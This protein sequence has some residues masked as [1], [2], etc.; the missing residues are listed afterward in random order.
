MPSSTHAAPDPEAQRPLAP[1]GR[2]CHP[3]PWALSAALLLLAAACAAC[4]VRAWAAPGAP[5][6]QVP[7][8][9][10]SPRLPEGLELMPDARTRL[11]DSPQGVFAQLVVADGVQLTE[12]PLHWCSERGMTGVTLAPGVS[13]DKHTH[14]VVVAQAGVYYVFLHLAL[15]R[16]MA[17]NGNSSGSVSVALNLRPLQAGAA[18][19]ALTLDLPPPSSGNSVAGFRSG[20]LHLDAGQRLSV[21]LHLAVREPR[22][23][24]LSADATVLGLFHVN[25]QVPTG[26]SLTQLT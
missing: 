26:L 17:S 4:L 7:G 9:A 14:E 18:A 5:A 11:P 2:S 6:S 1:S 3:L 10:R 23:W 8:S 24:Q 15:K 16:A 12:G 19:L 20:L 21:H 13:Y 22:A 25:T